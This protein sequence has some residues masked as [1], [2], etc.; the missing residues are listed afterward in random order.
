MSTNTINAAIENFINGNLSDAKQLAKRPSWRTLFLTLRDRYGKSDA[1]STAI[2]N[3]LKG[4]GTFQAACDAAPTPRPISPGQHPLK[5]TGNMV[6]L[7]EHPPCV[8]CGSI[9]P[10]AES[11]CGKPVCSDDCLANHAEHCNHCARELG[12]GSRSH[13]PDGSGT[14]LSGFIE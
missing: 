7:Y 13:Y 6:N 11:P 4:K 8:V 3:Y 9:D 10:G 14:N 1:E 2:A 12:N 5:L